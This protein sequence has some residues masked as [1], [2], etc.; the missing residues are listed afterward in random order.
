MQGRETVAEDQVV[1]LH[2]S[3][4]EQMTPAAAR[5]VDPVLTTVARGY[6]NADHI[7]PLLFPRVP[8]PS[9]GGQ[10][11]EFDRT[12]FR[13]AASRR[14]PGAET[15]RV[16]FGHAGKK[17]ALE[18]DRLLGTYP[19]EIEEEAALIGVDQSMRTVE[20]TM[21]LISLSRE[22]EAAQTV[23][24]AATYDASHVTALQGAAQWS[25]DNSDPTANIYDAVETIRQATGTRPNLVVLGAKVYSRVRRHPKVTAALSTERDR[26]ADLEDLARL[27]DIERVASGDAI[28][29]EGDDDSPSDVWGKYAI[30]A[31]TRTGPTTRFQPTFGLGYTLIGT[32]VSEPPRYDVGTH[33][34]LHPVCEEWSNEV[35]GQDA[36]YL[37]TGVIA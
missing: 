8:A 36:G 25:N 21:N 18:Q 11:I 17:F 12:D 16:Q 7:W 31:Y 5:I 10:I 13:K 26:I 24:K 29:V 1:A 4:G 3:A 28:Y 9:R 37:F 14:A 33:S 22:I 32:P 34:W 27:W 15:Q 35:V 23:T 6:R 20:G 30:V 19:V 2:A